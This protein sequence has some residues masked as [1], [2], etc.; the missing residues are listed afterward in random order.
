M[1]PSLFFANPISLRHPSGHST[2]TRPDKIHFSFGIGL[3]KTCQLRH[4]ILLVPLPSIPGSEIFSVTLSRCYFSLV[5]APRRSP[6]FCLPHGQ[7]L[8]PLT[9]FTFPNNLKKLD[10]AL[11]LDLKR[12]FRHGGATFSFQAGV[13]E[14]LNIFSQPH[15]DRQSRLNFSGLH[16]SR[17]GCRFYYDDHIYFHNFIRFYYLYYLFHIF[18]VILCPPSGTC[19]L[20]THNDL[21]SNWLDKVNG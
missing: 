3:L 5:P 12:S 6:F 19:I 2:Q 4:G 21:L 9:L 14:H 16:F 11:E 7:I 1:S 18:Q 17:L 13:P 15:G 8:S 20:R 10:S